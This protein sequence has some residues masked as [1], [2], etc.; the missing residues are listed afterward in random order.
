MARSYL[1]IGLT[2]F[3]ATCFIVLLKNQSKLENKEFDE[4]YGAMT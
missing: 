1:L 4:T 3:I 2:G